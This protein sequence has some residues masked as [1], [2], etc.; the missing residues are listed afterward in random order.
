MTLLELIKLL[1]MNYSGS[2]DEYE[3]FME[4]I[5]HCICEDEQNP[6]SG[7][8]KDTV[9]RGIRGQNGLNKSKLKKVNQL[10]EV[11][12]LSKYI[13]TMYSEDKTYIMESEIKSRIPEFNP[14][15][16]EFAYPCEDLFFQLLNGYINAANKRSKKNQ[17]STYHCVQSDNL[18]FD[19]DTDY[20]NLVVTLAEIFDVKY[21]DVS[22]ERSLAGISTPEEFRGDLKNRDKEFIA[23][24]YQYPALICQENTKYN[25][26]TDPNQ[27]C[28]LARI[29]RIKVAVRDVRIYFEPIA[30]FSQVLMNENSIEFDLDNTGTLTTLNRS[31]WSI[32]DANLKEAF[33]ETE[34]PLTF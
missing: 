27:I 12:R 30:T 13:E 26:E 16:A 21:V 23:S 19:M 24:L 28:I 25:G 15:G 5:D 10:R 8:E 4:L 1:N 32:R 11:S 34:I 22:L 17:E 7:I 31:H 9:E 14:D 18:T 29:K 3:F 2:L 33:E 20:Y 6:F